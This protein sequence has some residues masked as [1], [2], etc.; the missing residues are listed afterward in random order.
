MKKLK[1]GIVGLL[2]GECGGELMKYPNIEMHS[3]CDFNPTVL[4]QKTKVFKRAMQGGHQNPD[5]LLT[6]SDYD[7]FLASDV[8]V[9]FVATYAPKH[10]EHVIKALEAGK[11][12]F[13]EIPAIWSREDAVKLRA[14]VEAHPNQ[15]FMVAEN[16]CFWPFITSWKKMRE[17]GR[18]GDI[19]YAEGEYIH[20]EDWR[21]MKPEQYPES[22]WRYSSPAIQYLTHQLGPLLS[23]MDDKCVSVSCMVPDV[24]YNPYRKNKKNGVAL[25]RTA[26]GAVIRILICHD[27]YA[28]FDHNFALIGT[29]GTIETDKTKPLAEA[30]SFARFSDV[31][32]TMEEKI[33]IP[34]TI[35]LPGQK[36]SGGH[37]HAERVMFGEIYRYLMDEIPCPLDINAAIDMALPGIIAHESSLKGGELMQIPEL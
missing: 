25:F 9:V 26:K 10:T 16:C 3:I 4:E 22:H 6:F 35:N 27:A 11:H 7:E 8:E 36:S 12:V 32:G 34:I 13:T 14:A 1:Y 23:I 28:G 2:R 15:K 21:E 30:H 24:E 33:D 5:N 18:F 20:C 19:V 37:G 31:P 17:D 29:R